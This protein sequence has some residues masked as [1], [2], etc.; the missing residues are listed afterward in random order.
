MNFHENSNRLQVTI[1][2]HKWFHEPYYYV[3][4]VT[5]PKGPLIEAWGEEWSAYCAQHAIAGDRVGT[6]FLLGPYLVKVLDYD[7]IGRVTVLVQLNWWGG[8]AIPWY[9][10]TR[11]WWPD[12][13]SRLIATLCIWGVADW[14]E[15]GEYIHWGL[16]A[17]C[18][19]RR[20]KKITP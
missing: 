15:R 19:A 4:R 16:V 3:D 10:L 17:R 5:L 11:Q 7:P 13:A 9:H 14:P 6:V 12:I 2:Q 8:W 18:W 1:K 20:W